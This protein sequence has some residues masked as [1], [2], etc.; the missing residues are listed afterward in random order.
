MSEDDPKG[1]GPAQPTGKR[2][3][4]GANTTSASTYESKKVARTEQDST[5]KLGGGLV[6]F[7]GE[8]VSELRKVVWPTGRQ[9]VNYT[10]IVF[11]FLIIMTAIVWGVDALATRGVEAVLG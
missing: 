1:Q 8:V 4:S 9:M 7:P 10:V 3:L 6:A 2:Q 5:E 11:A